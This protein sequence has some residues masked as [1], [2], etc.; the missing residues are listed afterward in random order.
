MRARDRPSLL[1]ADMV[2][3]RT[4]SGY[5]RSADGSSSPTCCGSQAYP[6]LMR[7]SS[8]ILDLS[9]LGPDEAIIFCPANHS[10]TGRRRL[11]ISRTVYEVARHF[12]ERRAQ[13]TYAAYERR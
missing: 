9:A 13:W 7:R 12:G 8:S 1:G 6:F 4:G 10:P 5:A 3:Q 11:L 2:E